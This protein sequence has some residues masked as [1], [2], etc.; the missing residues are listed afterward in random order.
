VAGPPTPLLAGSSGR[1]WPPGRDGEARRGGTSS[2]TASGGALGSG[3]ALAGSVGCAEEASGL[4][5]DWARAVG[6]VLWLVRW[7]RA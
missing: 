2:A 4:V 3:R 6:L 7:R 1:T 5:G